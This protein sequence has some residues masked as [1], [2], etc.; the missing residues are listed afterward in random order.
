M[1]LATVFATSLFGLCDGVAIKMLMAY[2]AAAELRL[3]LNGVR[4]LVLFLAHVFL[5]GFAA[6]ADRAAL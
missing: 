6:L 1:L 5:S 2:P 4:R 3:F